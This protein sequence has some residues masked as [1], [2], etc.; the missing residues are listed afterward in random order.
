MIDTAWG[1]LNGWRSLRVA[2]TTICGSVSIAATRCGPN[3]H[4]NAITA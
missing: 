4:P 2:V 1:V 3:I